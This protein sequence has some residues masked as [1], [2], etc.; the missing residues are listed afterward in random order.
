MAPHSSCCAG[1]GVR[2]GAALGAIGLRVGHS[3]AAIGADDF[4]AG[5]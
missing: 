3:L 1:N 4:L 5:E 2:A